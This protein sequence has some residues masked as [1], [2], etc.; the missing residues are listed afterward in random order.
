M[1]ASNKDLENI[2]FVSLAFTTSTFQM[3]FFSSTM[4]MDID[5]VNNFN[6]IRGRFHALSNVSSK[7]ASIV[8][9]A[10]LILYH[11]RMTINNDLP[12]QEYVEP[13]GSS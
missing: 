10:S 11:E 5:N 13:I 6:D 3:P 12:N 1:V 8:S 2:C 7:S 4:E 9:R